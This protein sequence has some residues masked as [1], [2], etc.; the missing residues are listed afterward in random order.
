MESF[1]IANKYHDRGARRRR[2]SAHM[3]RPPST[4]RQ[5]P[6]NSSFSKMKPTACAISS[7]SPSRPSGLGAVVL[8][9]ASGFM[10][11]TI[12]VRM[13]PGATAPPR[14]PERADDAVLVGRVGDVAAG[15]HSGLGALGARLVHPFAV[16]IHQREIGAL[17]G[18]VEGEGAADAATGAG[19]EN[20]LVADIHLA[21]TPVVLEFERA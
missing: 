18:K 9:S 1:C 14:T 2:G 15:R 7:G 20:G 10:L 3:R 6:L 11:S 21:V 12:G 4:S 5:R 13:N 16:G 17:A 19:H 8:A